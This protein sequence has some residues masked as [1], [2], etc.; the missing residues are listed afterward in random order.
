VAVEAPEEENILLKLRREIEAE[1][2]AA[3]ARRREG[4]SPLPPAQEEAVA[5]TGPFGGA[6]AEE[7]PD[8]SLLVEGKYLVSG[9]GTEADPYK[10]SWDHL[11]SAE[12]DYSPKDGKTTVPERIKA[13][14]GKW[15]EITGY[16]AFPLVSDETDECLSMMNQWDGCCIGIPPTPYDAIEVRLGSTVTGDTRLTTYGVIKGR[17]KVDPHLVGGWLVGMYVMDQAKLTPKAFGGVAP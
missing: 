11:I 17:F 10:V 7:R 2:A 15:V 12:R 1:R 3:E 14:D 6:H 8:G 5:A 13:L 9:K 4:E 16:I